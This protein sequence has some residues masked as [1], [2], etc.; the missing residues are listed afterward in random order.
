LNSCARTKLD[1]LE[2]EAGLA[3]PFTLTA[4]RLDP[5]RFIRPQLTLLA[6]SLPAG[7]GWGKLKP[8]ETKKMTVSKPPPRTNRFG[9]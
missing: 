6:E 9:L 1:E 4:K 5:P 3:P 8:L 2:T 7:D